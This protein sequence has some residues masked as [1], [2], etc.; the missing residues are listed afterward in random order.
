MMQSPQGF[1]PYT[2][3]SK[4]TFKA[5]PQDKAGQQGF[6]INGNQQ[7]QRPQL[8]A[9]QGLS[10]TKE[11]QNPAVTGNQASPMS[12]LKALFTKATMGTGEKAAISAKNLVNQLET[13]LAAYKPQPNPHD[14][15][16]P[17]SFT[18]DVLNT[19]KQQ[20][21]EN[22][23]AIQEAL[24]EDLKSTIGG[25]ASDFTIENTLQASKKA[26]Q[27]NP[28]SE[29][30]FLSALKESLTEAKE[31]KI[32]TFLNDFKTEMLLSEVECKKETSRM[33]D[34]LAYQRKGI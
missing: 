5:T 3:M 10:I 33:E 34:I 22:K 25:N 4:M 23:S 20:V 19:V 30:L 18:Q 29:F 9:Q 24:T 13:R 31:G 21:S 11:Q 16:G 15:D 17:L 2:S 8:P 14:V 26:L 7:P 27:N 32:E 12:K 6:S 1:K 28:R